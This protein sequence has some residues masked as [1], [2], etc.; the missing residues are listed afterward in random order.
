[1][2]KILMAVVIATTMFAAF[3]ANAQ[4]SHLDKR[5]AF[6]VKGGLNLS[7]MSFSYDV[8]EPNEP[9]LKFGF[10]AGL[11]FEYRINRL[12]GVS[13][14]PMYSMQGFRISYEGTIPVLVDYEVTGGLTANYIQ[15]PLMLKFYPFGGLFIEAGPQ[16]GFCIGA[17]TDETVVKIG[18]TEEKTPSVDLKSGDDYNV[19][20]FGVGFGAGWDFGHF[21]VSARYNLGITNFAATLNDGDESV[22]NNNIMVSVGFKF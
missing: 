22:K 16:F 4:T 9:K 3:N 7:N 1:M 12:L 11:I 10:H 14:E 8:D 15:V 6:G 2:K 17:S 13:L 21:F 19:F 20:D 18:S 5:F